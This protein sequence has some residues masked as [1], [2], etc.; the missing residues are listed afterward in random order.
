MVGLDFVSTVESAI[1]VFIVSMFRVV[2]G[3]DLPEWPGGRNTGF[4]S[5]NCC[6]S[7][8]ERRL[9]PQIFRRANGS[10]T[11]AWSHPIEKV[12]CFQVSDSP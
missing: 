1:K 6:D 7:K 2:V 11:Q 4:P 12:A 5:G 10:E 8:A 9:T 3:H